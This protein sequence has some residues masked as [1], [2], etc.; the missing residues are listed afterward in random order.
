[1]GRGLQKLTAV[2]GGG[3]NGGVRTDVFN[4][5]AAADV[6]GSSAAFGEGDSPPKP[7]PIMQIKTGELSP[8]QEDERR[9]YA[10]AV[11]K[12]TKD[13]LRVATVE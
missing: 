5:A 13:H 2:F 1:M 3:S 7:A 9:Y 11:I 10:T 12:E 8:L 6:P 4:R